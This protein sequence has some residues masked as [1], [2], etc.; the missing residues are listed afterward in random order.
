MGGADLP[1]DLREWPADPFELLGVDRSAADTDIKRAYSR[2]IRR[3]KPEHHPDQFRRIRE[4]YEACLER[5]TWFRPHTPSPP[6]PPRPVSPRSDPSPDADEPVVRHSP[7]LER[8]ARQFDPPP[9]P[10]ESLWELALDGQEEEAYRSLVRLM[11]SDP[12]NEVL[13]LRLYWLL[14]LN[15][16]LDAHRTRHHWLADALVR[17]RLSGP[18][19]EL[20]RRELEANPEQA[21]DD[22]HD[23][24]PYSGVLGIEANPSAVMTV[25]RWRV[26]AAG[27][28]GWTARM[29]SDLM[30]AWVVLPMADEPGWLSL[31]VAAASWAA[32]FDSVTFDHFLQSEVRALIHLQL[33][34]APLFDRLE[35]AE[36]IANVRDWTGY[37]MR[38]GAFF[39]LVRMAWAD[40]G[41]ARPPAVVAAAVDLSGWRPALD[42]LD[43]SFGHRPLFLELV[44]R[45]FEHYLRNRELLDTPEFPPDLLRGLA[46]RLEVFRPISYVSVQSKFLDLLVA[47]AVHPL[48]MAAALSSDGDPHYR[49]FAVELHAD[50]SLRVVWLAHRV[51]NG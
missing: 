46:R 32:W 14:A 16:A 9:D 20:Y 38:P 3:F 1:D 31:L 35:E 19:L 36:R 2:L 37:G 21:L 26:S 49:Q 23:P 17:G 39:D 29:L 44:A 48:E 6:P 47:H 34:H 11:E 51:L 18:A 24:G 12:D 43:S 10:V 42:I 33:S 15:P 4:A 13:P 50:R 40:S 22:P 41:Y 30:Q 27:R 28:I 5:A 45:E 25:A 8:T 7:D